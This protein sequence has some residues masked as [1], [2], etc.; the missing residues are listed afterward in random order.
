LQF[1]SAEVLILSYRLAPKQLSLCCNYASFSQ[2]EEEQL[3][4]RPSICC[5]EKTFCCI[6]FLKL[7][8]HDVQQYLVPSI[9]S[10]LSSILLLLLLTI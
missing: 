6:L 1:I 7:Y 9:V 2:L 8:T 4:L 10:I 3:P 5:R